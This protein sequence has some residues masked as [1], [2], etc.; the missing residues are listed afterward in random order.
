MAGALDGIR[1][2][3][4]SNVVSGPMAVQILADQGA[5]V[6]KVE[7]PGGGDM[8]RLWGEVRGGV[9]L[10]SALHHRPNSGEKEPAPTASGLDRY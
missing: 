3:D 2:I 1:I 6:I 7:V 5:D 10:R 4:L 8:A 9:G